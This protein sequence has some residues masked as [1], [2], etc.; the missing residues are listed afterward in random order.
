M[1]RIAERLISFLEKRNIILEKDRDIYV[2]GAD[3]ALYTLF[4]T[5]GLLLVGL[6]LKRFPETLVLILLFYTNQSNGGGFH[7]KTHTRCFITM[8]VGLL[9]Y[10]AM[11]QRSYSNPLLIVIA[12]FSFAVLLYFPLIL[13]PNKKYLAPKSGALSKRSRLVTLVQAAL[14]VV[15]IFFKCAF[16]IQCTSLSLGLCALSRM[17]AVMLDKL[18]NRA[19]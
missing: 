4:S 3:N 18:G 12:C 2:Y 16:L 11:L 14:F 6:L 13:H 8:V 10:L 5:S 17:T 9:V 7:A 19:C 1:R 15:L